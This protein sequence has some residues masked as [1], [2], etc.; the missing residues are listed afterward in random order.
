MWALN[1]VNG[2]QTEANRKGIGKVYFAKISHDDVFRI[3]FLTWVEKIPCDVNFEC[4]CVC[5]SISSMPL[6]NFAS[7]RIVE[8]FE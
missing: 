7:L 8:I 4:V 5:E 6:S 3:T 2:F 1:D